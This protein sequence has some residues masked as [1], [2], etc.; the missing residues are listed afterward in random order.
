[1][2]TTVYNLDKK[3]VGEIDLNDAVFG[4]DVNEALLYDVLKAQLASKRQGT[5]AA[6]NRAAVVGSRKKIYRQKGTGNA[7]HGDKQAPIFRGGGQAHPPKPRSY[8]YRPTRKMRQ[9][10]M[11]SALSLRAQEGRLTVVENFELDAIKT[12]A[13]AGI[14]N[15]LEVGSAVLV[16]AAENNNLK[17]SA[18]NLKG[19]VVLP[20]EGINLYDLLRHDHLV[21]TQAAVSAIV[22]RFEG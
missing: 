19:F 5:S 7:R 4:V 18:R 16:D 12:K 2:K 21:V 11:K 14:L 17:L 10:A 9:G 15:K 13:L 22:E 6:K 3:S 20:P 8:A 1:M